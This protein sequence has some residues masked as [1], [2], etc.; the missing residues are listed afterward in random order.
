MW[1]VEAHDPPDRR[2]ALSSSPIPAATHRRDAPAA[3]APEQCRDLLDYL[4][5]IP[6]PGIDAAD[7]TRWARCC[8]WP[9]P[10]WW[11]APVPW[12]RSV[13]GPATRP[14]RCWRRSGCAVTPDRRLAATWRGHRAPRAG[15]HRRRRPR[16]CHRCLAS[17]PA[18][19]ST[20][21]PATGGPLA[22][23]G[24]RHRRQDPARQRPPQRPAGPPAGGN[25]PHHP[26]DPGA[27]RCRPH[28]QRDRPVP[29]AAGPPGPHRH[30]G[31]CR[32]APHPTRACRLAGHPKARRLPADGER[33]TS[34]PCTSSYDACHGARSPSPTTPAT[35]AT[36][37]SSSA[38]CRSPPSLAWTSPTPPRR[39]A[40]PAGSGPCIA[41]AGG[42]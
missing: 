2:P 6:D 22:A 16:P 17:C 42:P 10:R 20:G 39:S 9:W 29:A 21:E 23:P 35:A 13:S 33:P 37:A 34:P 36:A 38:T 5:Q 18:A 8:P 26:R 30:R 28:H 27:D 25:G 24:G 11:P 40:S 32:C 3:L 15:P 1:V 4:A 14:A 41:A 7:G 12:P 31:H 19:T